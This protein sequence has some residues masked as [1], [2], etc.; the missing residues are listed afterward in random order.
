MTIDVALRSGLVLRDAA[1]ILIEKFRQWPWE[2]YD[3]D[4][5]LDS[6]VIDPARDIDRVYRLGSRTPRS[7]YV[8]LLE[9]NRDKLS[10]C[11]RRIPTDITLEDADLPSLRAPIAEVF[12]LILASKHVKMAGA[13]KLLYPFRPSLLP[14]VDS[15]VDYY[16]WYATSIRDEPAFRRLESVRTWGEYI[17]D[18]LQLM[19]NDIEG[20]RSA[21][22]DVLAACRGRD[23]SSASRVRV[24]ESLIWYYYA[25]AGVVRGPTADQ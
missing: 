3:G 10:A 12:D 21:I 14:V 25:R 8:Q 18:I 22:D 9:A 4:P 16:Y 7:A 17:F 23:F 15:V 11:L 1:G 6:N 2:K 20:A 19:K 5:P 13:T 24:L